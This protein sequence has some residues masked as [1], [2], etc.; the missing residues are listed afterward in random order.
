MGHHS[1]SIPYR[2]IYI[3]LF[4]ITKMNERIKELAEQARVKS[5][6]SI[7]EARYLVNYLNEEKF[8]ELIVKECAGMFDKNETEYAIPEQRIH[9]SI[10][11]HFGLY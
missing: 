3:S 10:M 6:W 2:S 7:D 8:A 9:N 11:I 1:P 5:H 4:G